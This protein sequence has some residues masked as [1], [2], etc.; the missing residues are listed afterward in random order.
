MKQVG[1]KIQFESRAE[2]G[3]VL[4]MMEQYFKEHPEA[5]KTENLKRFFDLID[6]MEMVW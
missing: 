3:A 2:L 5:K 4:Q 1:D 6:Y